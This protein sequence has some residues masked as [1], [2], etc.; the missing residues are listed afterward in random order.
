M[1]ASPNE[2]E[3]ED[4]T[5]LAEPIRSIEI[6]PLKL[7]Q[8]TQ[9]ETKADKDSAAKGFGQSQTGKDSANRTARSP[10][11]ASAKA[12]PASQKTPADSVKTA[13]SPNGSA[14]ASEGR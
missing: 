10:I 2:R 13:A 7:A 9:S 14:T 12:G 5:T 4:T 11:G 3:P 8:H 1:A 6:H